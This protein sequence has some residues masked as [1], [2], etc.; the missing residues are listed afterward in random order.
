[1]VPVED[2]DFKTI[3]TQSFKDRNKNYDFLESNAKGSTSVKG[4]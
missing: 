3:G 2:R 1:V 4:S